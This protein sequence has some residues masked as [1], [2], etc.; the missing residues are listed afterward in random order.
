MSSFPSF[1]RCL[2]RRE[3]NSRSWPVVASLFYCLPAVA[4]GDVVFDPLFLEQ[5]AGE[6]IDI[7]RFNGAYRIPPGSYASDVYL[8]DRLLGRENVTVEEKEGESMICFSQALANLTAFRINQLSTAQQEALRQ[9]KSCRS[10]ESLVTTASAQLV[11][12][13]M[14]LNLQI[15][16]AWL[17]RAVR[18]YVDPERWEA[19]SN[20]LYA[21]Y[22][23]SYF[24]QTS[25]RFDAESWY[26]RLG[27]SINLHGWMFRHA[28]AWRW[29]KNNGSGYGV[30]SNNLQRDITSL[31]ARV[32]I[33]DANSS[34]TLFNAFMFRGVRLATAEQ[35]LPDSQ[36]GYAPVVRGI[37]QTHARVQ[38]RQNNALIYETTVPPGEFMINDIYPSGY[39]GDLRVTVTEADGQETAFVVPYAAV[40]EMIRAGS[41]RYSLLMG[42]LRNQN[43]GYTPKVFQATVQYGISNGLTGYSGLLGSGDYLAGLLGGATDTRVGAFALDVT[44]ARFNDGISAQRGVSVRASYSKF[45]PVTNSSVS[46]AAYRFS[47]SGYL[48]LNNATR[49]ADFHQKKHQVGWLLLNRPQNRFS[50]A[51]NQRLGENGGNIYASGYAENYWDRPGSDV[52][53]QLGYTSRFAWVNYG[54]SINRTSTDTYRETQYL[55]SFSL[56]LGRG[57]HGPYLNSYTVRNDEGVATQ[58]AL[59]G[60]WGEKDQLDYNVGAARESNGDS[61]GNIAGSY[62]FTGTQL[63][64][65]YAKGKNYHSWTAGMNGSLVLLP[66]ALVASPYSGDTQ[67]VIQAEGAAGASVEGYPG[68]MVNDAGYALV[69]W[70]TPYRINKIAINP[71]GMPLDVELESTVKQVV[72]RAGAIVKV[73]YP[74]KQGSAVLIQA[75]LPNGEALPFGASVKTADG[76]DVGVVAQGGQMYLRLE[77]PINRLQVSWGPQSRYTCLFAVNLP[78]K[79]AKRQHQFQRF[80]TTCHYPPPSVRQETI[81]KAVKQS[82]R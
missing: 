66:D 26:S 75:Q 78:E 64:A 55:L 45:I 58:L 24:K 61:S 79:R 7:S 57:S 14:R 51:V 18:G 68:V 49:L 31:R 2:T 8:N 63:K 15:P 54:L 60:V 42:T 40:S 47:S 50:L 20:A 1:Y 35:M 37:A 73:T 17:N 34:G 43:V 41:Y 6:R 27:G 59:S 70:L 29:N 46:L 12:A 23:N 22:D 62:R 53:Y 9:G 71:S 52:Q 21:S 5:A 81:A 39:G 72:P 80:N 4:G 28:G 76:R 69:P 30:L 11:L 44:G 56:P 65:S 19:G 25:G 16:Q 13:D 67:A 77:D 3:L 10:L 74:T 33:G 38:I 48:D 32:L 82:Q 36:R